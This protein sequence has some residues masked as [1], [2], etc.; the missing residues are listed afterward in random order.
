[1][2]ELES[3]TQN[4]HNCISSFV[5]WDGLASEVFVSLQNRELFLGCCRKK[6]TAFHTLGTLYFYGNSDWTSV[7]EY[8]QREGD[9]APSCVNR[10]KGE[11]S[12]A[13]TSYL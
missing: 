12:G 11:E 3:V 13:E 7:L 6:M 10:E 9:G 2:F 1:M 5:I 8:G 4:V